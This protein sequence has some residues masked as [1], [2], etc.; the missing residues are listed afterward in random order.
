MVHP[1]AYKCPYKSQGGSRE[2][3][4]EAIDSAIREDR[5]NF[6]NGLVIDEVKKLGEFWPP[7]WQHLGFGILSYVYLQYLQ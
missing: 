6:Q 3:F 2:C 4:E 7:F 1:A 5:E